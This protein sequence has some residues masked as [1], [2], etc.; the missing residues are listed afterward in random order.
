MS[1][2]VWIMLK[3]STMIKLNHYGELFRILWMDGRIVTLDLFESQNMLVICWSLDTFP[4]LLI[5]RS[6]RVDHVFF[7]CA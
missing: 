5:F 1:R 3:L 7:Y 6:K 2:T 4:S